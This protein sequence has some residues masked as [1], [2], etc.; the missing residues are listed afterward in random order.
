MAKACGHACGAYH[1]QHASLRHHIR[2]GAG[3][4]AALGST[5]TAAGKFSWRGSLDW[6][7]ARP[8]LDRLLAIDKELDDHQ[9]MV[10]VDLATMV[11]PTTERFYAAVA[12]LTLGPDIKIAN[13]VR[14]LTPGR[15]RAP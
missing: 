14:D 4:L 3:V 2:I 1:R 12:V 8:A 6:Y 15:R 13:A 5:M 9:R 7:T 10:A 11:T